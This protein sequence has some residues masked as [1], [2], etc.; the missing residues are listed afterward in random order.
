MPK[1][2][3]NLALKKLNVICKNLD[4]ALRNYRKIP[5]YGRND[6]ATCNTQRGGVWQR[7]SRYQT[8]KPY[9]ILSP[10]PPL[11]PLQNHCQW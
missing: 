4:E 11:I 9:V 8:L 5:P 3:K 2:L 7:R 1:V 6:T 10:T